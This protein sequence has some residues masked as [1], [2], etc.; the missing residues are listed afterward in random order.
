MMTAEAIRKRRTSKDYDGRE[1]PDSVL[2]EALELANLAPN[3]KINQPWRFRVL[4]RAG[5]LALINY[6][7]AGLSMDEQESFA[8][9]LERL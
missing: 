2:L 1:V 4:R 7:K 5:V 6:L 9:P 8:K 3:H